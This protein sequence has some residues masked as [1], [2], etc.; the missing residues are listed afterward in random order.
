MR[1][2]E[3]GSERYT[4]DEKPN[5]VLVAGVLDIIVRCDAAAGPNLPINT[6]PSAPTTSF[7]HMRRASKVKAKLRYTAR[8]AIYDISAGGRAKRPE[9]ARSML[10]PNI[11]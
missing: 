1:S 9:L 4:V 6:D 3:E 7:L 8:L 11:S 2:R 10:C 5:L